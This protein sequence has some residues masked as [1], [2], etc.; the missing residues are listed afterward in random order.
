VFIDVVLRY[1]FNNSSI[2]LQEL[3]WHLFSA[4]FLLS[5]AYGLQNDIHVRV[6]VFYLNF[7][8]KTQALINIIGSAVFILPISLLITY[9]LF[10]F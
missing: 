9:A 5:I 10:I 6:D 7:S 3:E 8:P 2:A 1:A 4:M